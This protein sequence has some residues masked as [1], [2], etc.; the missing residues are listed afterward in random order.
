[1]D[2]FQEGFQGYGGRYVGYMIIMAL[3]RFRVIK[4]V[5]QSLVLTLLLV[6]LEKF[7]G[8]RKIYYLSV[9][10][11]FAM[12]IWMKSQT[13]AWASGFANYVTSV[14]F[15]LVYMVHIYKL[16]DEDT[17][18]ELEDKK[19]IHTV[20]FFLLGVVNSLIVEHFT[21]LN[22]CLCIFTIGFSYLK[23]KK[24]CRTDVAYLLGV[25]I[26]VIVMFSNPCYGNVFSGTDNYRHVVRGGI[27]NSLGI[28]FAKIANFSLLHFA[29]V[30]LVLAEVMLL[31][32]KSHKE[33]LSPWQ[34]VFAGVSTYGFAIGAVLLAV[35][36]A[37]RENNLAIYSFK[38]M[39]L[40]ICMV[41]GAVM[42]VG[43]IS[44]SCKRFFQCMLPLISI[45]ILNA[46]F[47]FVN[48]VTPRCFFGSYI[49]FILL[50]YQL[51]NLVPEEK[52][53]AFDG[54]KAQL[55]QLMVAYIAILFN[56]FIY[57]RIHREDKAR[58]E[59]VRRQAEAGEKIIGIEKLSLEE[60]VHDI[61][62][63]ADWEWD[64]YKEFYGIDM[65]VEIVVI[66]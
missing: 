51:M 36:Y 63:K 47:L 25:I 27:L 48:P 11:I 28:G 66:E 52:W 3:T 49:M 33:S 43:I 46:Q 14:T 10:L 15:T 50:I 18:Q 2:R 9:I 8:G 30:M 53:T 39:A 57:A 55:M 45:L 26:S 59:Y 56:L 5:F 6:L 20:G 38:L 44:F 4:V 22:I 58:N 61:T 13:I 54:N 60:Y 41:G 31:A 23:F 35:K 7:S 16:L 29:L 62:L 12:P 21:M 32:L 19:L 64:G 65:D 40:A 37:M 17:P 1:M 24:L 34:K 42:A